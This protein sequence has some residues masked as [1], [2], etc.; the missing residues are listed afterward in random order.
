[1]C[2]EREVIMEKPLIGIAGNILIMEGGMFP[3]LYRSYVNHD[4]IISIEKSG[5]IPVILP[6]NSEGDEL[7]KILSRLDGIVLSG[8]SDIDPLLY[9]EEPL[10]RQGFVFKDVDEF[11]IKLIHKAAQ[12]HLPILG[13]C[14]GIQAM[15]V[16]YGGTLYQDLE[17][18]KGDVYKHT[19]QTPREIP[20]HSISV[21]KGS[22]LS[23]LGET[24]LVNSFHHQAIK[25]VAPGFE[26]TAYAK[27][28]VIEAIERTNDGFMLGVQW[29]PEMM[30]SHDDEIMRKLFTGFIEVCQKGGVSK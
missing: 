23:S 6:V 19:Q 14:K 27:D 24:I 16:A 3:G 28:G 2:D 17:V 18:Q 15:N 7:A 11:Y 12:V 29:H 30:A 5:G 4:Y 10:P 22:Y 1:M 8:G 25:D 20:T 21:K 13:I 9:G 26:V